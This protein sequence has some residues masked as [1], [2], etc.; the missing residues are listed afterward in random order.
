MCTPLKSA[1]IK[2]STRDIALV[3]LMGALLVLGKEAL[4]FLPNIEMVT[5]L[6]IVYTVGLG[7]KRALLA[8]LL[9]S[10]LEIPIY[11]VNTWVLMY[12]INWPLLVGLTV[13]VQKWLK[14]NLMYALLSGLWGVLFGIFCAF[15]QA[16]FYTGSKSYLA[17]AW[18]YW[19]AGLSFD[20]LHV[21]GNFIFAL[22]FSGFLVRLCLR[23]SKSG[24][25][26]A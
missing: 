21:A 25:V 12:F 1:P 7:W 2:I 18:A 15:E 11:G 22:L 3:A 6:L 9:F 17:Y 10:A 24:R 23:L 5:L 4:N 13:L 20:A 8:S 19:L 14:N 26:Q 16:F